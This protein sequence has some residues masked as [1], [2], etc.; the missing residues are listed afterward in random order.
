MGQTETTSIGSVP[1]SVSTSMG[2][3]GGVDVGMLL[4]QIQ[5]D[6]AT[7]QKLMREAITP[8][9]GSHVGQIPSALTK[10]IGPAPQS[11]TPYERP[12]S[13][14]EAISNMI[15]SAGNAVSKVITAEKEQK[16]THLTDAATKLFTAQ[17]AIDEAQQQHDSATA[18]GDNATAQKAQQL[19]DQ[20]TK[21]RDGITSDPKL[22]KALAKGLNIDYID[23]SNNKTEEH[24]AVKKALINVQGFR[25]KREAAAQAKKDFQAKNQPVAAQNFATAFSKSQPQGMAPNMMAQQKIVMQQANTKAQME[26]TKALIPLWVE[27]KRAATEI[28]KANNANQEAWRRIQERERSQKELQTSRFV[29]QRHMI[30]Y[31][32]SAAATRESNRLA[33]V[34][35]DP[36]TLARNSQASAAED[37]RLVNSTQNQLISLQAQI[38]TTTDEALKTSLNSQLEAVEDRLELQQSNSNLHLQTWNAFKLRAGMPAQTLEPL[39]PVGVSNATK[40][41]GTSTVNAANSSN[42]INHSDGP[43]NAQ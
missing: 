27:D 38:A 14:G 3:G 19:I 20:N 17:A 16:Q 2:S 10:P 13:K 41:A 1:A 22:R 7:Q 30:D 42:Y 18:I 21:V 4:R 26:Y 6:T 28:V 39:V 9:S 11:Q 25:E 15:N 23:P 31:E 5:G 32:T 36:T 40:P 37:S 29:Q 43:A 35:S 12:R 33:L 24:D 34:N 8:V